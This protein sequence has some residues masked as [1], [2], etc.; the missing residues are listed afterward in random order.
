MK[1]LA[2]L[3]QGRKAARTLVYAALFH[4]GVVRIIAHR[5]RQQAKILAY[6]SVVPQENAFTQG[7]AVAVKPETFEQQIRYLRRCYR[8]VSLQQLI[9]EVRTGG[10]VARSVALTFDDGFKDNYQFA[11]PILRKYG[12]PATVFLCTDAVDNQSILWVHRLT[13]LGNRAGGR[14]LQQLAQEHI[15]LRD[16]QERSQ[17]PEPFMAVMNQLVTQVAPARREQ[18]LSLAFAGLGVH[19]PR[20]DAASLYLSWDEIHEMADDGVSFGNHTRAHPTLSLLTEAEQRVQIEGAQ[21]IIARRL[22]SLAMPFAYPFGGPH[23]YNELSRQIA[24]ESGH[25]CIL[26][27][28]SGWPNT[29]DTPLD[30]LDRIKVEEEPLALFA[31]RIEGISIRR[32]LRPWYQ[33]S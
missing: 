15:G 28:G 6:H 7:I 18:F 12:I 19:E 5:H 16:Q 27:A 9:A 8:I 13:F 33:V 21:A 1:R 10:L 30:K 22:G 25:T 24:I 3:E 11:W 26:S 23:H 31:A 17:S 29:L 2:A 4:S 20:P 32:G 14:A